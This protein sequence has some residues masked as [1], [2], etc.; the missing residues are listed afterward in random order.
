VINPV[1]F[2]VDFWDASLAVVY[3]FV[4][5]IFLGWAGEPE[6][7]HLHLPGAVKAALGERRT[8]QQ[9]EEYGCMTIPHGGLD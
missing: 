3:A 8:G 4:E 5:Q 9:Q 2:H 1:S 6:G 7:V